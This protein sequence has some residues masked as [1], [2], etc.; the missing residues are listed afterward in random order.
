[1][2]KLRIHAIR[3]KNTRGGKSMYIIETDIIESSCA[4]RT[5]GMRCSSFID[6]GNVN[7]R[8]KHIAAFTAA[9]HGFDPEQIPPESVTAP[10]V[11]QAT[12][13]PKEWDKYAMESIADA[14]PWG[15]RE[16]ECQVSTIQVGQDKHDWSLHSWAPSGKLTIP[17]PQPAAFPQFQQGPPPQQQLPQGPPQGAPQGAPG[18]GP[19]QGQPQAQPAP[20]GA[21]GQEGPP[22]QGGFAPPQAGP[23]GAWGQGQ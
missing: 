3:Y 12:G 19:P 18:F 6:M 9:V 20:Q 7:T 22:N 15:G 1:M 8:G 5:P 21:P 2:Y 14:N 10:W 4:E 23:P 17:A 13:Q 16:V 11:D